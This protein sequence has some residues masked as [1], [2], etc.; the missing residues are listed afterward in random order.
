MRAVDCFIH[1]AL[2]VVGVRPVECARTIQQG[3]RQNARRTMINRI[4]GYLPTND[5]SQQAALDL[6]L[7]AMES[8]VLRRE[9]PKA[10]KIY[11]EGGNSMSYAELTLTS[12]TSDGSYSAGSHVWGVNDKGEQ[13]TGKTMDAVDWTAEDGNVTLLVLY[14]N[15]VD[16]PCRVGALHLVSAGS[17]YNCKK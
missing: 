8:L 6:D 7:T 12:L 2:L 3:L 16:V 14:D 15:D 5:V 17:T 9:L 13:I 11:E 1:A 10:K 4:D